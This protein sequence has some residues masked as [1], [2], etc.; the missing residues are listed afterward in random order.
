MRLNFWL[1]QQQLLGQGSAIP[2]ANKCPGVSILAVLTVSVPNL[3]SS[4]ESFFEAAS[5]VTEKRV[6]TDR[7]GLAFQAWPFD[8]QVPALPNVIVAL[9]SAVKSRNSLKPW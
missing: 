5:L 9:G 8:P 4:S 7:K 2:V 1:L 3:V 6:V